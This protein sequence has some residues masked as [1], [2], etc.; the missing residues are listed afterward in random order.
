MLTSCNLVTMVT[1][2]YSGLAN[3][4]F[5]A[6]IT[7]MENKDKS[8]V[9]ALFM[10]STINSSENFEKS[11]DELLEYYNGKMTSY[12]DVSSGG[13]FVERNLFIG[14]RV[15]M[16]SY[17]VVETD[18]DKYHFDITECV[19]DSLNPGNVGIK[20]LYIINDKDF[21][22][23]DGYYHGD[24]KNT[25]GINIGKYAEYSEDTVMSRE[26]FNN[27]L[28]AVENKDKDTLGSYFSKNA[29]EKTPDFDNEVEKLLN[30]YKGTHKPFNRYTG[31]GSVYEMNDWGTEYKYLDSN[32]YLETEEGKNFYFKISE[33]L[34][35]EKDRRIKKPA[36]IYIYRYNGTNPGN[37]IPMAKDKNT[38][39]S[40]STIP[41]IN[42]KTAAVTTIEEVNST[43]NLIAVQDGPSHVSIKPRNG[44]MSD[45]IKA[46]TNSIW[47]KTLKRIVKRYPR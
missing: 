14:K 12:D 13:E 7:A 1:G 36:P 17:F 46:G 44:T 26:K 21:P 38:G 34:I 24:Y 11:L 37:L 10:D 28:T 42:N 22:D 9:K 27:L 18:G 39:L 3:R 23:K 5:N 6:L 40:F 41:P 4:N 33:Y 15:F 45:W 32:F 16:S 35:K 20:S 29:V 47:T 30:L 19:F 25:E 43:G 2:D 8:A 31:G